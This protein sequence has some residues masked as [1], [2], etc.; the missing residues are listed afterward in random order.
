M[1]IKILIFDVDGTLY[2]LNNHEIPQSCIRGLQE[3]RRHG[4]KIAIATGRAHYGLGKALA[5]LQAD[6]ILSANG[7]VVVE[8]GTHIISHQDF[9]LAE[10]ESLL[11]FA[12]EQ[13][14]GLVFKFLDHMYIYQYPE[15]VDWLAGQLSSD[16]GKEPFIYHNEQTRH[17]QDLPQC[18]S[19]HADPD[20]IS[21][22]AKTSTLSF[23]RFSEYGFDVAPA[24]VDKGTG[25]KQLLTH[26]HLSSEEAACF[27]DNYNDLPM[28]EQVGYCIAMGN[29]V[30]EVK[31]K[32]DFITADCDQDGIYLGLKHLGCI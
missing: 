24:H 11:A 5:R 20:A 31:Q 22:F 27:G 4:Y 28:M 16:I 29:A 10:C 12:K 14:A 26:L 7:G 17:L 8:Q 18:A 1:K 19:I 2:D 6:F 32:A 25:V 15:K 21:Q 30:D 9:T 13:E 3:V 23:Q